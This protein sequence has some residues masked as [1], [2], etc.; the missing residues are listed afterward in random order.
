MLAQRASRPAS[1]ACR[2]AAGVAWGLI[3]ALSAAPLVPVFGVKRAVKLLE[4]VHARSHGYHAH[5]NG[6]DFLEK[7]T[8][9]SPGTASKVLGSPCNR[10]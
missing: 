7:Q 4:H 8:I 9:T 2:V 5:G 10:E 3:P 1:S 6:G